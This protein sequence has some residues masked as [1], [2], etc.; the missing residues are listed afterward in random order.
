MSQAAT[1]SPVL[2]AIFDRRSVRH[3]IE[4]PVEK[5]LLMEALKAAS[6]APSGLNN[7]PWR[8][9]VIR[10]PELK[11]RLGGLTRYTNVLKSA[12]VL[13]AFFLDRDSSYDYVKDCQAIGASIEN[14][15]LAVHAQDLGAVW[16]GEI[17]KNKDEVQRILELPERL[18]LMAIVAVGH[19]AHRSQSSHR[20]PV[21]ELI[22]FDR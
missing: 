22:L 5:E 16:I 1:D 6:W 15:L 17:L 21:E 12:S 20:R 19:P 13:V 2:K 10:D 11:A 7:Q 18:D 8:F 14:F 3:F 9:G 4:A